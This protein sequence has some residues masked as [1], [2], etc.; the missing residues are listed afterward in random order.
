MI[1]HQFWYGV[2]KLLKLSIAKNTYYNNQKSSVERY[3][4]A[5]NLNKSFTKFNNTFIKAP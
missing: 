3:D 4:I 5:D 1:H 2:I